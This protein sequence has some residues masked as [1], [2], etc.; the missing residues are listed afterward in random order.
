MTTLTDL[1]GA[2]LHGARLDGVTLIE[3]DLGW[4]NLTG[5]DLRCA[6]L[7]RAILT[8]AR[9]VNADLTGATLRGALLTNADLTGATLDLADL[10]GA[11]LVLANPEAAASLLNARFD[12]VDGLSAEQ[13]RACRAKGALFGDAEPARTKGN[14]HGEREQPGRV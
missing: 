12:N 2:D 11:D 5:A 13:R 8:G 9:F 1:T 7:N 3:A 10:T 4:T 14:S 6:K